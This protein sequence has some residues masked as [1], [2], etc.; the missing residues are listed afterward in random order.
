PHAPH[1]PLHSFPTRRSSDLHPTTHSQEND[2][3][4][5][6]R[7]PPPQT[8][9]TPPRQSARIPPWCG[10]SLHECR[11]LRKRTPCTHQC[12]THQHHAPDRKSTR[13]NSSHVSISYAV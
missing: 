11:H 12:L 5:D 1:P 8:S 6:R 2:Q 13:L 10:D 3:R 7:L 9:H 4:K